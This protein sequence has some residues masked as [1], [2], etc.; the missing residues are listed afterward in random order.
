[1]MAPAPAG[2]LAGLGLGRYPRT[3]FLRSG[4]GIT[5]SYLALHGEAGNTYLALVAGEPL[6]LEQLVSLQPGQR[7]RLSLRARSRDADARL[8]VPVCEKWMLYSSRCN[9]QTLWIGDTGGAMAP[10]FHQ[11]RRAPGRRAVAPGAAP[12][13]AVAVQRGRRQPGRHR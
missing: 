13:E 10:V 7:Y 8:S 11:R 5:P 3:Y 4:E 6:Y 2:W 12:A 1:M 9:W